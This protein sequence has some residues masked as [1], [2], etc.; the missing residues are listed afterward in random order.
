MIGY[1]WDRVKADQPMPGLIVRGKGVTIRRA[2]DDLLLA[3]FCGAPED[4]KNQVKHLP[5]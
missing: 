3:V 1:A 5:L 2:I 4:F